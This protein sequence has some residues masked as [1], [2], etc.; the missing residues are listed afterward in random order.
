MNDWQRIQDI[1]AQVLDCDPDDRDKILDQACAGD[2]A[3]RSEVESL[4]K[5]HDESDAGFMQPPAQPLPLPDRSITAAADTATQPDPL[6]GQHIG[7]YVI[8]KILASGGMGTVYLAQQQQPRRLVALK[9][10]R[11]GL[12][13]TSALRRFEYEAEILAHL[14]HP[15]IAE[16]YEADTHL[17]LPYFVMEYIP[18][19]QAITDYADKRQ[20]SARERLELFTQVCDAVHHGHQRGIIHRDLKPANILVDAYGRVK[21]IDF[22]IARS[23][24]ADIAL[25]TLRT[26]TGELVGTLQYMSPEQCA[27]DPHEIDIRSD[28]Y[29]LGMVLYELLCGQLPY[30]VTHSALASAARV[31]CEQSPPRPSSVTGKKGRSGTGLQ[32]VEKNQ[33]GTGF[34][35]VECDRVNC[36]TGLQPVNGVR[37]A[38]VPAV[39]PPVKGDLERIILK[40]LEKDRRQRY[41]SAAD[42]LRDVRHYLNREPIEAKPPTL[43]TRAV[44]W[45]GRHPVG[46]T[47]TLCCLVAALIVGGT[48]LSIQALK[49]QPQRMEVSQDESETRLISF[50]ESVMYT[51]YSGKAHGIAFAELVDRPDEFGGGQ[52]AL[53][54]FREL[55]IERGQPTLQAFDVA[56]SFKDPVWV[57]RITHDDALP[58]TPERTHT[59]QIF[60]VKMASV[61]DIFEESPGPEVVAVHTAGAHSQCFIRIY[62]LAGTVVYQTWYDGA[63]PG[64]YWMRKEKLLVFCGDNAE[65]CW[66]DRGY[67]G[68]PPTR[69]YPLVVFAIR[70]EYG[71]IQS[72]F[73][74]STPGEDSL[75]PTWLKCV[76][77]QT[78]GNHFGMTLAPP[79]SRAESGVCFSLMGPHGVSV[80]WDLDSR[81]ETP[82]E[83][84]V[85]NDAYK[86]NQSLPKNNPDRLHI[87]WDELK[88]DALPPIQSA[89][90][91]AMEGP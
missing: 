76:L 73:L 5:H 71:L 66:R 69:T 74:K 16:I 51:W 35:P 43:W 59:P 45:V 22:G 78:A 75:S 47:T 50:I 65:A 11:A 2:A 86:Q 21:V 4:L 28:V 55:E 61:A 33:Y 49:R 58:N 15:H 27:A 82:P 13:S 88:L 56:R 12:A 84:P 3:L 9:L 44:R 1:F 14:R 10:L 31:I 63:L 64:C 24:D 60:H 87:H 52:L 42:L 79:L 53:I 68:A 57:G 18:D 67:P 8:N 26:E 37:E 85:I 25:T 72:A 83:P 80:A 17:G 29:S 90:W 30:D 38:N 20:L 91:P 46:T 23:T 54:G 70:P 34:Q 19:A 32:P 36:G 48:M 89:G 81:G 7:H 62:D 40:S 41:Q 6:L 77:P 39:I